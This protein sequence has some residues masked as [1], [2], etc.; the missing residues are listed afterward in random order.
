MAQVGRLKHKFQRFEMVLIE[1]GW[2]PLVG[3]SEGGDD[4]LFHNS[5]KLFDQLNNNQQT[6]GSVG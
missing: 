6:K 1:G 3:F 4:V 2:G 5:R